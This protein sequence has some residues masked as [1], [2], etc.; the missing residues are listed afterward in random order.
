MTKQELL[1]ALE[2]VAHDTVI[3]LSVGNVVGAEIKGV[4]YSPGERTVGIT[5]YSSSP[6][7]VYLES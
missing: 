5:E 7:I 1:H 4:R 3:K 2:N 6:G